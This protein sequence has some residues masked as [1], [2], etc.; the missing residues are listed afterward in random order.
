M[1]VHI[2]KFKVSSCEFAANFLP[3]RKTKRSVECLAF[4]NRFLL[5]NCDVQRQRFETQFPQR[6]TDAHQIGQTFGRNRRQSQIEKL[7]FCKP[8]VSLSGENR[9]AV[10][11]KV[12]T[13]ALNGREGDEEN[14]TVV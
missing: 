10:D 4:S 11:L 1:P 5:E 8:N 13:D 7:K 6:S 2:V 14:F 9:V 12:T 3:K